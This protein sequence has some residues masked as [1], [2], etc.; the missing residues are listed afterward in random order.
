MDRDTAIIVAA[1]GLSGVLVGGIITAGITAY[2]NYIVAGRQEVAQA[3]RD[4]RA[5]RNE[6]KTAVRLIVRKYY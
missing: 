1:I 4:S 3:E 5:R 2:T 6:L